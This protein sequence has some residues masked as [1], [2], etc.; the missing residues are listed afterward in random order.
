MN[1]ILL[2]TTLNLGLFVLLIPLFGNNLFM[3]LLTHPH[4]YCIL[5]FYLVF[6]FLQQH[7]LPLLH[8]FVHSFDFLNHSFLFFREKINSISHF[9]DILIDCR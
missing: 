5:D 4:V 2:E 8:Y 3:L 6:P 7:L 1:H 9:Y